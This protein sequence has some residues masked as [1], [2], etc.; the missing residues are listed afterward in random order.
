MIHGKIVNMIFNRIQGLFIKKHSNTCEWNYFGLY[1]NDC[2]VL[3]E[4]LV[5]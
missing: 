1:G 5:E 4:M 3:F 2:N